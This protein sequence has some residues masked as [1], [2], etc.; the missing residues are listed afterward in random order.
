MAGGATSPRT[1]STRCAPVSPARAGERPAWS[2]RSPSSST[3]ARA[4]R[5]QAGSAPPSSRT[6]PA[7][8]EQYVGRLVTL[9]HHGI[10]ESGAL[11]HPVY[12]GVRD[13]ADKA[14]PTP[15]PRRQ[16]TVDDAAIQRAASRAPGKRRNYPAMKPKNLIPAIQSLRDRCGDAYDI[17]M[18]RGSKDPDGDLAVALAAAKK[19]GLD[20]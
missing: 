10:E 7:T 3:A 14:P 15:A 5:S 12:L 1:A 16:R 4:D 20:V 17:C 2:V 13:P 8:P 18:E 9:A 11:R 6:S 19:K